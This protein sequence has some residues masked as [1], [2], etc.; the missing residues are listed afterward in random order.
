MRCTS[1]FKNS[2]CCA[3]GVMPIFKVLHLSNN[4]HVSMAPFCGCKCARMGYSQRKKLS[5]QPSFV[6]INDK[7]RCGA[8]DYD[9]FES[10]G[11]CLFL[12]F[13]S[14]KMGTTASLQNKLVSSI[15][16]HNSTAMLG[17]RTTTPNQGTTQS[18]SSNATRRLHQQFL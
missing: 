1:T 15:R 8:I 10:W 17:H 16:S 3:R 18:L 13:R 4:M 2:P 11:F 9:L 14:F 12:P 7:M 5:A 6:C